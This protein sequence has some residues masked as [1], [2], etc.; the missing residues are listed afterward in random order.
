MS[1]PPVWIAGVGMTPFGVRRDASV[2]DL[3]RDAVTE[4]LKDAGGRLGDVD[5]AYFGNTCQSVLEGQLVVPGQMALRSMGFERIP[6]I[7][8]ENACATGATALHQ[9]VLHVR[10]GAADVVLTVGVEKTNVDDKRKMLGLF[11]G[12]VDVHDPDGVRAVLRELGG[13]VL[14]DAGV[15]RSMFMDIYGALARSHMKTFGTT[16]RHLA[17][18]AEKNH[19]HAVSDPLAHFRKAMS[20]EEILAARTVTEPLTV[21]MCA[22]L[23]DGAA[24]AIVCNEAGRARLGGSRH[25][26][27]LASVLGTGTVRSLADWEHSVS[28]LAAQD[29]YEQAG[30]GPQDVSVAEVHDASVFGELLQHE[31]SHDPPDTA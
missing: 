7:N 21:P 5:A 24:A 6:V 2:K 25:V 15:P 10:S 28:A 9:A 27:V 13:D 29:A 31:A 26:R 14:D 22:P 30:I 20:A 8:V 23:T 3:T 19:A 17:L 16:K 4:A 1:A 12:G 18:I 11:D